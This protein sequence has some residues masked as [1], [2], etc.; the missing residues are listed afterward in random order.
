MMEAGRELDA[1]VAELMGWTGV[2]GAFNEAFWP[3]GTPPENQGVGVVGG[4]DIQV[5]VPDYSTDI[6]AAWEVVEKVCN[7]DVGDNML[8]LKGQGPDPSNPD[9]PGNWW[10]AE[11]NG[12]EIG[13]VKAEADTAPEAI[14]LAA[15]KV[16]GV[17]A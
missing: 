10:E 15:L 17:E 3:V 9:D 5:L 13:K 4:L 2:R 16:K 1:L 8:V 11:I 14:C 7:W 12:I 6:A